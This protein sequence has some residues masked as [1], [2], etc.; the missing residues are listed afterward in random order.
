M[1]TIEHVCSFDFLIIV[2]CPEIINGLDMTAVHCLDT[3]SQKWKKP[4]KIIGSAKSIV[5]FRKEKRLYILQ[6]DGK[7]WEVNQEEVSSVRLK[8]LKR[9]WNGNIKMY[10][11]IN[12][13]E[14]LYFITG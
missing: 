11:V 6:T 12:I 4:D 10:G 13:N 3:R 7:L 14:F 2:F 1:Q 9:L 8:L 5:S